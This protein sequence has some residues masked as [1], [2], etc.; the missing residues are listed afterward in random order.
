MT[1]KAIESLVLTHEE[2]DILVKAN[3]LVGRIYNDTADHGVLE[4]I[5]SPLV[6]FLDDLLEYEYLKVE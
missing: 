3:K 4:A 2:Y 1:V 6:D 5:T